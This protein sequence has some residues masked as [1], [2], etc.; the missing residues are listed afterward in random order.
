MSDLMSYLFETNAV[1]VCPDNK[2]FWYTS[3]KIGPYFINAQ[4]LYG[5]EEDATKFLSYIDEQLENPNKTELPRNLFLETKKQYDCNLIYKDVINQMKEFIEKNIDVSEIDYI[6][7]GERRDWYFSNIIAHLLNK[8]HITIYKDLSTI[9]SNYDFTENK[10]VSNLE[11]KKVLHI[12]DLLNQASSYIRAW[13]P[14]IQNLGAEIL[15]S[16]VAVDR[17]QGGTK[18]IEDLGIK[19]LALVN[20]DPSLFTKALEMKIINE[21]QLDM[22]NKFYE[23]PDE[24]MKEFLINHPDFIQNALNSDAKSAKRARLCLDNNLYNL[25]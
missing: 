2:P 1:K 22:L 18:R 16:V 25:D 21:N 12:A 5:S 9:V 17:M 11:G 6:S 7:G 3:G 8:P 24:T 14:A 4:F 13:I 10:T 19:S 23:N 20:I 15:W